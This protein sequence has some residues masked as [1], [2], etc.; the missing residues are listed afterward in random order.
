MSRVSWAIKIKGKGP[1]SIKRLCT[2]LGVVKGEGTL[3][4]MLLWEFQMAG[5]GVCMKAG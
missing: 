2:K 4:E 5:D 3:S 1:T